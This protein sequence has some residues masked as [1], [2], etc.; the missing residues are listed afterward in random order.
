MWHGEVH[1]AITGSTKTM[2][3]NELNFRLLAK[4][5]NQNHWILDLKNNKFFHEIES[6]KKN[7][8]A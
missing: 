5:L 6:K 4:I 1:W 3:Q 2:T 7:S 8:V